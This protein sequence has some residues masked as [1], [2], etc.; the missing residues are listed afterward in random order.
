MPKKKSATTP[1]DK[2]VT[3]EDALQQL[4]EVVKKLETGD[5]SL[6]QALKLYEDGVS[7][8]RQC[9]DQLSQAERRVALLDDTSKG[10]KRKPF[11]Q[12]ESDQD[13][14]DDEEDED[15]DDWD[16]DEDEDEDDDDDLDDDEDDEDDDD[17]DE[18]DEADDDTLGA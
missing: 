11:N 5:A 12:Q 13:D 15:D 2:K 10:I 17:W 18:D 6:D 9:Q 16:D 3:F 8:S 4:E 1:K 7:L 14:E